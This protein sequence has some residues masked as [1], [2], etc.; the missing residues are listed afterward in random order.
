[1]PPR[2][3][4]RRYLVRKKEAKIAV[5]NEFGADIVSLSYDELNKL[6]D[7]FMIRIPKESNSIGLFS[8]Q[9]GQL[10]GYILKG[11]LQLA[12]DNQTYHLEEGDSVYF[13][14]RRNFQFTN[15][16]Q[17][18]AEILCVTSFKNL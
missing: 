14:A 7:T 2:K 16:G 4:W 5:S 1:M 3:D 17:E 12:L 8:K 6:M 11:E 15:H 18:P 9:A 13:N 10:F